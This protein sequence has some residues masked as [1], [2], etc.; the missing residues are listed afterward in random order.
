VTSVSIFLLQAFVIV[1]V[2][3][4]LLRVSGLKGMMPLVV[5][6]IMVG[7]ALGPSFFGRAAPEYFQIFTSPATLSS[8]SGLA[9]IGVLISA[10]YPD[11]ILTPAFSAATN[12]RSGL[13]QPRTW[14]FR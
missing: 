2:P 7:I 4:V 8:L 5:M 14:P 13:L 11:C 6:Q 10:S 12:G 3:V 1:A 9:A